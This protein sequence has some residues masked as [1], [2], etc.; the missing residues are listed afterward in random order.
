MRSSISVLDSPG[1]F[2]GH[3]AEFQCSVSG[4]TVPAF[5]RVLRSWE[6]W[7]KWGLGE[8]RRLKNLQRNGRGGGTS[9]SLIRPPG[10]LQDCIDISLHLAMRCVS[11]NEG[12][13]VGVRASILDSPSQSEGWQWLPCRIWF[14]FRAPSLQG[15]GRIIL[16]NWSLAAPF[17]SF[18]V[19][20]QVPFVKE[21]VQLAEHPL[22]AHWGEVRISKGLQDVDTC[23]DPVKTDI[24][25]PRLLLWLRNSTFW[26]W[27]THY[28]VAA[29]AGELS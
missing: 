22:R 5:E 28:F 23:L 18:C 3:S 12:P 21:S 17:G 25:K 2:P 15:E 16:T 10:R 9:P 13:S 11:L 8:S 24:L 1:A 19:R 29:M 6:T 14:L 7:K 27:W 4:P 20:C 26:W